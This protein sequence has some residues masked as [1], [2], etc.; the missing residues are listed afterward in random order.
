MLNHRFHIRTVFVPGIGKRYMLVD[1]VTGRKDSK[2]YKTMH[3][4]MNGRWHL[5][6]RLE[7]AACGVLHT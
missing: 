4:A 3:A 7:Y 2:T 1:D 6:R 5:E